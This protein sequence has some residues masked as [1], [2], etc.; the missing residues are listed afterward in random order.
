MVLGPQ[1]NFAKVP[2][3]GAFF[4]AVTKVF[5]LKRGK[6]EQRGEDLYIE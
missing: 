4:K 6:V 2:G 5:P 1:G 3:L